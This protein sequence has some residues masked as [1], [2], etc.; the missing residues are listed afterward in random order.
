MLVYQNETF[1]P[2]AP[3]IPFRTDSEA[4]AIANDTPYGLSSGICTGDEQRGL[5]IA[6]GLQTGMTHINCSPI[7]D[8]PNAPFGGAKSSG[9]GRYGGRW[10]MENFTETR[11]ITLE[12]GGKKIPPAF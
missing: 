5:A 2:I 6:E 4:V 10:G 3:V 7:N 11:W 1:G 9:V 8:E 12:R